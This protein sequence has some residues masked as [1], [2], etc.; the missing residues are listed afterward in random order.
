MDDCNLEK[1]P[2][3]E[4]LGRYIEAGELRA[5]A[6]DTI[7]AIR[8]FIL[9]G[10]QDLAAQCLCDAFW[11][12]MPYSMTVTEL[13]AETVRALEEVSNGI[14]VATPQLKNEVCTL[15]TIS[16]SLRFTNGLRQLDMFRALL[17]GDEVT[18]GILSEVFCGS[19]DARQ[20]AAGLRCLDYLSQQEQVIDSMTF[21]EVEQL[22][23]RLQLFG[24][25]FRKLSR[26]QNLQAS[27]SVQRL[28]GFK[29][30]DTG[31]EATVF[32]TSCIPT[33]AG[34]KLSIKGSGEKGNLVVNAQ[35]LGF[36]IAQFVAQRLVSVLYNYGA[37]CLR[38]KPFS[39]L[40]YAYLEGWK[41]DCECRRLHYRKEEVPQFY[42][43]QVRLYLKQL[44]VLSQGEPWEFGERVTQRK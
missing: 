17:A 4:D 8:L 19:D 24:T 43:K 1:A 16:L 39:S 34:Q 32:P 42:N 7:D 9:G 27:A 40:C 26:G 31:V 37:A 12:Q 6:G 28:F 22:Q 36:W 30:E 20:E 35:E 25:R 15:S 13:N 18:L 11:E 33:L 41:Q 14:N 5:A 3:L 38:S 23:A 44:H 29:L 2:I 10:D 21:E